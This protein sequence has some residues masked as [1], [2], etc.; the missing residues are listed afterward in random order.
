MSSEETIE[1]QGGVRMPA[2][3]FGCAFGDW[4]GATDFQGFLPAA[5]QS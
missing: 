1:L 3:A 2:V 4:V 5:G